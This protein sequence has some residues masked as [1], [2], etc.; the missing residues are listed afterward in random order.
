MKTS[1]VQSCVAWC[2]IGFVS[3]LQMSPAVAGTADAGP[4]MTQGSPFPG[5]PAPSANAERNKRR[6]RVDITFTKWVTASPLMEGVTG[7]DVPGAFVGEILE[8]QVSQR[9]AETCYLPAPNCGRVIRLE[10]LYEVQAGDRSFV[11]LMRGGTSGDTGAAQLDGTVLFGWRTGSQ[12]HVEFQT[13]RPASPTDSACDGAPAGKVCFQG[14]IHI[15]QAP[16]S[17]EVATP[18]SPKPM[19]SGRS[20]QAGSARLSRARAPISQGSSARTDRR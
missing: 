15:E 17:N 20:P 14:T 9:Q 12:V 7:G 13:M 16:E 5:F 4:A 10:A 1:A 11:A 6:G 2:V 8:R 18:E 3:L 19:S